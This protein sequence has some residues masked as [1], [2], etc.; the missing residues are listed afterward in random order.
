[1]ERSEDWERKNIEPKMERR[2]ESVEMKDEEVEAS[3]AGKASTMRAGAAGGS[4]LIRFLF[5]F[6]SS[7]IAF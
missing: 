2:R 1:M 3:W 4:L 7:F 5:F 6:S